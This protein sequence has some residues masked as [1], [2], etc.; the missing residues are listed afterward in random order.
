MNHHESFP[1]FTRRQVLAAGGASALA[2]SMSRPGIASDIIRGKAEHVI[3][4][5]LGGGMGAGDTFD[6]KAK[7]D[8][9]KKHAGS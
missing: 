8:P 4:I 7:G 5:W 3:S 6:P 9:A 2:A 1:G